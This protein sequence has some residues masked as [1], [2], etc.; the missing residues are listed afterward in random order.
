[1]HAFFEEKF[2]LR[3]T[4]EKEKEE[5]NHLDVT[6]DLEKEEYRPYKKANDTPIYVNTLTS[7]PARVIK[8]IPSGINKRLS[9]ISSNEENVNKAKDIYQKALNDS[10]HQHELKYQPPEEN[11]KEKEKQKQSKEKRKRKIIWFNPPFS[12]GDKT[13]LERSF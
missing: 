8:Q 5:V 9:A 6:L 13:K 4:V 12:L 7:H 2:G 3:I 1:M 11:D 10:G